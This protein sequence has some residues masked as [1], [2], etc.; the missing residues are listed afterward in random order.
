MNLISFIQYLFLTICFIFIPAW[1]FIFLTAYILEVKNV[2]KNTLLIPL[3]LL[4]IQLGLWHFYFNG[5]RIYELDLVFMTIAL[6]AIVLI[7][8][9]YIDKHSFKVHL[10]FIP[11]ILEVV[12]ILIYLYH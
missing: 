7:A 11:F 6:L 2:L 1:F 8:L 9:T 12:W 4:F 10:Y 5:N 3:S